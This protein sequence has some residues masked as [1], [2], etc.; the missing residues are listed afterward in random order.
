M[1]CHTPRSAISF[2]QDRLKKSKRL[3]DKKE[4]QIY[5]TL[6]D[7]IGGIIEKIEE[8]KDIMFSESESIFLDLLELC[9]SINCE[10]MKGP[11]RS[12]FK[13]DHEM[14]VDEIERIG[15]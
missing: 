3:I 15:L 13:E 7:L 6:T 10:E 1:V 5:F 4:I 12:Y 11:I 14:D 2:T 9:E 8:I